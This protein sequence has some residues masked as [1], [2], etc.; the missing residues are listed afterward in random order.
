LVVS[1]ASVRKAP[2][3]CNGHEVTDPREQCG[4]R[5]CEGGSGSLLWPGDVI[6]FFVGLM[7]YYP[8]GEL[9]HWAIPYDSG[10]GQDEV[11]WV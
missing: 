4:G 7:L 8:L 1:D 6:S 10:Y 9:V 5:T 11:K 3:T 2:T